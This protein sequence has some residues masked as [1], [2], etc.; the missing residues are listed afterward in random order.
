M[1]KTIEPT[2]RAVADALAQRWGGHWQ[3]LEDVR[4]PELILS[5]LGDAE[6]AV[7]AVGPILRAQIAE[8]IKA[9][10]R[11]T[12]TP[13]WSKASE[14]GQAIGYDVGLGAAYAEILYPRKGS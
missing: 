8:E 1:P 10:P 7:A 4:P 5:I 3:S 9:M 6:V 12:G 2:V 14:V 11:R 13:E